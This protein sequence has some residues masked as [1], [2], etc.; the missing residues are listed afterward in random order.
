MGIVLPIVCRRPLTFE[1]NNLP[2]LKGLQNQGVSMQTPCIIT[3]K[4]QHGRNLIILV[5][6]EF[7]VPSQ[8]R[9]CNI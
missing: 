8:L 5:R 2:F 6:F 4:I 9:L 3:F 1:N 7:S